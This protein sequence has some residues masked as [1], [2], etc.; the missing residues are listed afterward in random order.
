MVSPF[1]EG[2]AVRPICKEIELDDPT[3]ATPIAGGTPVPLTT[4]AVATATSLT[5]GAL[6][7][8]GST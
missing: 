6:R 8:Q 4:V 2:S 3:N 7:I 1:G 5:L